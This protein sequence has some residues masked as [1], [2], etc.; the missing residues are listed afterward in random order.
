MNAEEFYTM[1]AC[2]DAHWWYAGLRDMLSRMLRHYARVP[3]KRVLDVGC[4]T[5]RNLQLLKEHFPGA[6]VAGADLE[7]LGLSLSQGRN[8]GA[9]LAQAS[10]MSLP[11]KD[12]E[13]DLITAMDVLY[14][15]NVE[16]APALAECRRVL[17]PGGILLIN[18]PAFECLR[19]SHDRAVG[20]L[21]RYTRRR[22]CDK[23][24]SSGLKVRQS[25][26]WNCS[27][28][29]LAWVSRRLNRSPV[30]D[31]RQE[32]AFFNRLAFAFV[33]LENAWA[34]GGN[35][36]WGTSVFCAAEK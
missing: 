31:V 1:R 11:F 18:L 7:G 14:H 33:K 21:R 29:P 30:S 4:G 6:Q 19:G 23:L 5:G 36:P 28:F 25:A 26:Y 15:Q 2:E 12:A 17:R 3:V 9:A 20:G 16:E 27:L 13:V 10:I 24:A 34:A 8:L 22:I 35:A 32:P